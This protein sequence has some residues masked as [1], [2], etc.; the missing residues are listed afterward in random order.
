MLFKNK[1]TEISLGLS[2]DA[3]NLLYVVDKPRSANRLNKPARPQQY[4]I[5][6]TTSLPNILIINMNGIK[7]IAAFR[8]LTPSRM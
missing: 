3:K 1:K 8:I 5:L 6:P 2:S 4:A 7:P